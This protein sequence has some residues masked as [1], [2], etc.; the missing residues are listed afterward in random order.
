MAPV[1]VP[2]YHG[3]GSRAQVKY[4]EGRDFCAPI[5]LT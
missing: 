1:Q 2:T 5:R 3:T 4:D